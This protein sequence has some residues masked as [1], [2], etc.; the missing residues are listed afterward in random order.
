MVM[1]ERT[2]DIQALQ[3]RERIAVATAAAMFVA[4]VILM[5]AILPAEYGVDPLGTGRLLG[6]T[7]IAEAESAPAVA[8]TAGSTSL[9]PLQPGA[10]TAQKAGFKRDTKTF[11]IAPG[12]GIEYKYRMEQGG[13][14]VYSWKATG[15]VKS[16]FHGEPVGAPKGYAEFYEK[17]DAQAADGSFFAP[18]TGI[19]GWYWENLTKQNVTVTLTSAGFYSGGIKFSRTGREDMPIP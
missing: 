16:E 18:K 7:Q 13:S 9:E 19:H 8:A 10:N 3:Q 14:F 17:I 5:T 4:G 12:E 15:M 2:V 1:T 6:L 11:E